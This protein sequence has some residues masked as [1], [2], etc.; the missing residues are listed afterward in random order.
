MQYSWW[1][2]CSRALVSCFAATVGVLALCGALR[3]TGGAAP[4]LLLRALVVAI[5]AGVLEE[6]RFRGVLL[7]VLESALGSSLAL[8]VSAALFGVL[9]LIAPHSS[10][11][12]AIAIMLEGVSGHASSGLLQARLSGSA[13]LS[14][15]A[16]GAEASVA[17]IAVCLLAALILL[18]TAAGRGQLRAA[19]WT[20]PAAAAAT[21]PVS[22][23]P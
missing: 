5:A 7:R 15:G 3:I 8:G 19:P 4:R 12:S 2:A 20:R 13:G 23:C 1:P 21:A 11:L 10:W 16:F 14:G 6:L 22:S 17:A 18:A 9:P